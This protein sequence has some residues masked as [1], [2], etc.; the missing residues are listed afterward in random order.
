[1]EIK[2][3]A[4]EERQQVLKWL[5]TALMISAGK[6]DAKSC[7]RLAR[8]ILRLLDQRKDEIVYVSSEGEEEVKG[9]ESS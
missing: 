8:F 1:M 2:R 7:I 9:D 4:N 5:D 6:G 3:P